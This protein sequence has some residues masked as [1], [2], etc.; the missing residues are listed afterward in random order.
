FL[1]EEPLLMIGAQV[2]RQSRVVRQRGKALLTEK[3]GGIVDLFARQAIDNACIAAA[4]GEKRQQLLARLLLGHDAVK[5]IRPVKTGK[6]ALSVLQMQPLNDFF[7][8]PLV[9]GGS[10]RN[11]RY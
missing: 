4:L 11:A 3:R 8:S 2:A 9:G 10:K 6:K 5:D 7:T 1:V